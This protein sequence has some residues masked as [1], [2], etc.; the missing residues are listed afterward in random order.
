MLQRG[1]EET[2]GAAGGVEH[3]LILLRIEHLDHQV[4]R[5]A[6]GEVLASI[7]AQVGADEFLIGDALS[8]DIRADQVVRGELT[9]DE[10]KSP[11]GEGDFVGG[12]EDVLVLTL[13]VLE[14]LLDALA[15]GRATVRVEHLLQTGAEPAVHG[16]VTDPLVVHLGKEQVEE[17]P[18]GGVLRHALVAVD[19]VV[20]A[21]EGDL[22]HLRVGLAQ[23][24]VRGDGAAAEGAVG[25]LPV[26]TVLEVSAEVADHLLEEEEVDTVGPHAVRALRAVLVA[27]Q[28][29]ELL[30]VLPSLVGLAELDDVPPA[31]GLLLA[32]HHPPEVRRG[33]RGAGLEDRDVGLL[34]PLPLA[35]LLTDRDGEVALHVAGVDTV[36]V[37][38]GA[39]N[40][41]PDLLLLRLLDRI[42]GDVI[43]DLALLEGRDLG[44]GALRGRPHAVLGL[45]LDVQVQGQFLHRRATTFL[46]SVVRVGA[47]A[48]GQSVRALTQSPPVI[49][50]PKGRLR[51]R[52]PPGRRVRG[53]VF[54][55]PTG[56]R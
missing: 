9:D 42:A 12:L 28:L 24:L 46:C 34:A 18:E 48:P 45:L 20:A 44:R 35:T 50:R 3:G 16:A 51:R 47:C 54:P 11:I 30:Q 32:D 53:P 31:L 2:A 14:E 1:L 5:A 17:L 22:E 13:D 27:H 8:V 25:D 10:G 29:L 55:D 37:Y 6:R 43:D 7:T 52:V 15:D 56:E 26:A 21:P 36:L 19:V 23:P 49:L 33:V 41:L 4:D 39:G 40:P 38:Q